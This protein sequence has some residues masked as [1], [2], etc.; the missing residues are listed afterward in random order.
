MHIYVY[1]LVCTT[2]HSTHLPR[3]APY[4]EPTNLNFAIRHWSRR[5]KRQHGAWLAVPAHAHEQHAMDC[6]CQCIVPKYGSPCM[7]VNGF[8]EV[9]M[10]LDDIDMCA[11]VCLVKCTQKSAR[12]KA[13]CSSE[14]YLWFYTS[15]F[16]A[17]SCKPY[18]TFNAMCSL[19]Y[20]ECN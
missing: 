4:P 20:K 18:M 13:A 15:L 9:Y 1:T 5:Q 12:L 17:R 3:G 8:E 14:A 19:T 11:N 6:E 2:G 16:T 7:R 10:L